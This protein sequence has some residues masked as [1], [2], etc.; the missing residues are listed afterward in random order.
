MRGKLLAAAVFLLPVAPAYGADL[1]IAE[2]V[3]R[4]GDPGLAAA[5]SPSEG[6][7]LEWRRCPDGGTVC[8][9][10][11]ASA[12]VPV[13][14][15]RVAS[16]GETPAGTVFEAV[17]TKDGVETKVRTRPWQGRLTWTVSPTLQGEAAVGRTVTAAPGTSGGGWGQ[18]WQ[19]PAFSNAPRDR[20]YACR[21]PTGGDCWLIAYGTSVA[22]E[23]RWAGWYLFAEQNG[24]TSIPWCVSILGC[25]VSVA[26]AAPPVHIGPQPG[27]TAALSAPF[28]P[29][30]AA[31]VPAPRETKAPAASIRTRAVRRNGRLLVGRVSCET[32]R[33]VQLKVSGGGRRAVQRT[34]SVTGVK[35][36]TIPV[37]RGKL[38]V[39][40]VVDGKL[41][42][43][44]RTTYAR[45]AEPRR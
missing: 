16:P 20:I 31:P 39:R 6:V 4:S 42:A 43:S 11:P 35:S 9:P 17:A 41:L 28:G 8:E 1:R 24:P 23:P 30:A 36:L 12:D 19:S 18:D 40:V 10:L 27:Q 44:G 14:N 26:L 3:D 34:L 22:L 7:T 32:R 29:V 38:K 15:G 2:T 37:R 45:A 21:E 13:R 5:V 33:S 25:A